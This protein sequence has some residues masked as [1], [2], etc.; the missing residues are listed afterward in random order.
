MRLPPFRPQNS[1]T[2]LCMSD[3]IE[4]DEHGFKAVVRLPDGRRRAKR[5]AFKKY[6]GV[7]PAEQA[8]KAWRSELVLTM[9][10]GTFMTPITGERLIA[11][12]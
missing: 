2:V 1:G 6:G 11:T 3:W 4:R 9:H 5:F 7:R 8:A 10:R 12:G